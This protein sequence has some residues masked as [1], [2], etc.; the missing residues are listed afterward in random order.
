MMVG[1]ILTSVFFPTHR[2]ARQPCLESLSEVPGILSRPQSA[3]GPIRPKESPKRR[4]EQV[5]GVFFL[6]H[7]PLYR[8]HNL[9]ELR[10]MPRLKLRR[11]VRA[12]LSFLIHRSFKTFYHIFHHNHHADTKHHVSALLAVCIITAAFFLIPRLAG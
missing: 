10:V 8:R 3:E 9:L 6:G 2:L 1:C 11:I 4:M 7:L 12:S 5:I